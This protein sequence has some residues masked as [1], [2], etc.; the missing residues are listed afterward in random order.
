[1][2][3]WNSETIIEKSIFKMNQSSTYV[4]TQEQMTCCKTT[5]KKCKWTPEEDKALIESVKKNGMSNWS[6]VASD[7][8]GRTGKQ[9][10]ER[11][12]NQL[13][14][15]LNKNEWTA[16][17]DQILLEQHAIRGN[18]W[19]IISRFLPGR[20]LNSIKNRW[21][22]L[23]RH[24][25]TNALFTVSSTNLQQQNKLVLQ[26]LHSAGNTCSQ[27]KLP[28]VKLSIDTPQETQS[29]A[30][31]PNSYDSYTSPT[32]SAI[33]ES[34]IISYECENL[35]VQP[36]DE[37]D[38]NFNVGLSDDPISQDLDFVTKSDTSYWMF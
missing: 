12:T 25:I 35:P 1:M 34:P 38:I 2:K 28:L 5:T 22:W 30:C 15:E 24:N 9:C 14:P 10:R 13:C 23:S 31:T 6:L 21:S 4:L 18:M 37:L 8:K 33:S 19:S 16:H 27:Y 20:S 7:V 26:K 32:D 3:K 11:W 17:E 29:Q 36:M